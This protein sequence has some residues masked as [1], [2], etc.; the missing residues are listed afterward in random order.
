MVL[1]TLAQYLLLKS[2]RR[3]QM[4]GSVGYSSNEAEK[5]TQLP[6]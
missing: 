6:V 2:T 3:G 5:A 1:D 4:S